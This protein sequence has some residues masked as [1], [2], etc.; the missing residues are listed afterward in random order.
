MSPQA[1]L[2]APDEPD[3]AMSDALANNG[4]VDE[5]RH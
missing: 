2:E 4:A 3:L 1:R 5:S